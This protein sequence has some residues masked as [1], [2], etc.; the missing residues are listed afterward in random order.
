[1]ISKKPQLNPAPCNLPKI[2]PLQLPFEFFPYRELPRDKKV[3]LTMVKESADLRKM[4]QS[5]QR[6]V[7]SWKIMKISLK[8]RRESG[9]F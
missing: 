2:L 6:Q 3:S 1:M 7:F 4:L 5:M 9:N 8:N